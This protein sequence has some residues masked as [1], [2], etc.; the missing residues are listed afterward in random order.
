MPAHLVH[1]Y[2]TTGWIWVL[3]LVI[4]TWMTL[5]NLLIS[6]VTRYLS[7]LLI[8]K[9]HVYTSG[10]AVSSVFRCPLCA[11]YPFLS[12]ALLITVR[13]GWLVFVT[14]VNHV[15]P[16][17]W[18]IRDTIKGLGIAWLSHAHYSI[19]WTW[20]SLH[21]QPFSTGFFTQSSLAILLDSLCTFTSLFIA[22]HK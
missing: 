20:V 9:V 17:F 13:Y 8:S 1:C 3:R 14:I 12:K 2:T 15:W 11:S 18:A 6:N 19:Q 4:S 10:L 16:L 5:S 7:P 21:S 22:F